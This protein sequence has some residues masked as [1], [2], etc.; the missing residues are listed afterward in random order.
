M[1]GYIN[2]WETGCEIQ[3]L[4]DKGYSVD[5][6]MVQL[7]LNYRDYRDIY[8]YFERNYIKD[9]REMQANPNSI[10]HLNLSWATIGDLHSEGINNIQEIV[11]HLKRLEYG[12]LCYTSYRFACIESAV[13]S[14]AEE[15]EVS[16]DLPEDVVPN[17]PRFVYSMDDLR[18]CYEV[19]RYVKAERSLHETEKRF[20]ITKDK[21]LKSLSKYIRYRNSLNVV[22]EDADSL[23]LLDLDT[24][25]IRILRKNAKIYTISQLCTTSVEDIKSVREVGPKALSNIRQAIKAWNQTNPS[26][27]TKSAPILEDGV[28]VKYADDAENYLYNGSF[29][30]YRY[31]IC[32][33]IWFEILPMRYKGD[34]VKSANLYVLTK[35]RDK[36]GDMY[37]VRTSLAV[38]ASLEKCLQT[39]EK[40]R[41]ENFNTI[42]EDN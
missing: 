22:P 33:N 28:P 38:S 32:K 3:E 10:V 31:K 12:D 29:K 14:W 30:M 24:K 18:F 25:M 39:A 36:N 2:Y 4:L 20:H 6:I 11:P 27:V 37:C 35:S 23:K 7:H 13:E 17:S 26:E 15:N 21:V 19:Y 9:Y 42:K 8:R 1:F 40:Y 34:V 5:S 16:L 41:R